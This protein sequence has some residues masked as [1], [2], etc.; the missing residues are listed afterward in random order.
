MVIGLL[1]A[2][3]STF[4]VSQA[5]NATKTEKFA[6]VK[7]EVVDSVEFNAPSFVITN[8][9]HFDYQPVMI[10]PESLVITGN[11]SVKTVDTKIGKLKNKIYLRWLL[12]RNK[13]C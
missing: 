2:I 11:L 12:H 4:S 6:N 9:S 7:T 3:A 1:V 10:V 13:V 8:E 5:A